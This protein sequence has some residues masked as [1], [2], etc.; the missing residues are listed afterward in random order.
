MGGYRVKIAGEKGNLFGTT[1]LFHC[2]TK[3]SGATNYYIW[4]A[5]FIA[6]ESGLHRQVTPLWTHSYQT[7]LP[8]VTKANPSPFLPISTSF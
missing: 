4:D 8:R 5:V 1:Q 3:G 7:L 6:P 2:P